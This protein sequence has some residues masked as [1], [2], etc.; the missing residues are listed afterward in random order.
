MIRHERESGLS[1]RIDM[2]GVLGTAYPEIRLAPG[3]PGQVP[4]PEHLAG[5]QAAGEI[6]DGRTP[7]ERVVEVEEGTC[8]RVGLRWGLLHL[9]GGRGGRS[10]DGGPALT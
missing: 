10:C 2:V 7:D 8:R 4:R 3:H 9:G 1:Q 5:G 6:V